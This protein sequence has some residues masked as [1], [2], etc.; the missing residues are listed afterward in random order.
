MFAEIM[1]NREVLRLDPLLD[2]PREEV[3]EDP[4]FYMSQSLSK[5]NRLF[6]LLHQHYGASVDDVNQFIS[7]REPRLWQAIEQAWQRMDDDVLRLYLDQ[8]LDVETYRSWKQNVL[9][10]KRLVSAAVQLYRV[11]QGPVA[12]DTTLDLPKAA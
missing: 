8:Q 6:Q 9:L 1:E 2:R 11:H 10:W 4:S 7:T 5:V 12:S 3:V